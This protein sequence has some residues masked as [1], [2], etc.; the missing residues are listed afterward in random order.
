M[1]KLK[2]SSSIMKLKSNSKRQKSTE[3]FPI[4]YDGD[5]DSDDGGD[6]DDDDWNSDC[7]NVDDNQIFEKSRQSITHSQAIYTSRL[8]NPFTKIL[9]EYD[10]SKCL[11]CAIITEKIPER[12]VH[13]FIV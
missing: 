2:M 5:N 12:L 9:S 8:L 4:L 13:L 1:L 10:N 11:N 7:D 6:N 3:E